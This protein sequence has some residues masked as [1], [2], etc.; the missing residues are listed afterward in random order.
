VLYCVKIYCISIKGK[1]ILTGLGLLTPTVYFHPCCI[2][3]IHMKEYYYWSKIS[4]ELATFLF[5]VHALVCHENRI[6]LNSREWKNNLF[7]SIIWKNGMY[8]LNVS[9]SFGIR[10]E[11][12]VFYIERKRK[13]F[14]LTSTATLSPKS[15]IRKLTK[16]TDCNNEVWMNKWCYLVKCARFPSRH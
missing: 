12:G 15:K 16:F 3:F 7:H 14:Q 2:I 5:V 8:L 11:Y 10:H 13:I 9:S 1:S 6:S 4:I